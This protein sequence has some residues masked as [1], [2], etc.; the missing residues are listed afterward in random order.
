MATGV[1]GIRT[2]A[3]HRLQKEFWDL[4]AAGQLE[5]TRLGID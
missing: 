1:T 4:D 3:K 2:Q 5:K